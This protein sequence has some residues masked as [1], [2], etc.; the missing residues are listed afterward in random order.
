M[1]K[2]NISHGIKGRPLESLTEKQKRVVLKLLA[3]VSEKSFRRGFQH[4]QECGKDAIITGHDLRYG[5]HS[6]SLDES[7]E[8]V[9]GV[10]TI[11]SL[12]RLL[13]EN[14]NEIWD[15]G[16]GTTTIIAEI[17]KTPPTPDQI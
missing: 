15:A 5:K 1:S 16:I 8:P 10:R 7:F 4:G 2:T 17:Q 13:I 12:E 3:R 11:S 9:M 6:K 14:S